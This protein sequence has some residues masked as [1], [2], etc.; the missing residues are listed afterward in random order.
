MVQME[1]SPKV[2]HRFD[3][4]TN[5]MYEDEDFIEFKGDGA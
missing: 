5:E 1:L 4:F 3:P 2:K